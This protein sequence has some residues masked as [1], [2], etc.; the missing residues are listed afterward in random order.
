MTTPLELVRAAYDDYCA[1]RLDNVLSNF[2]DDIRWRSIGPV[3]AIPWAGD[4]CGRDAVRDW[5]GKL[6]SHL[7]IESY[8]VRRFIAQDEWVVALVDVV[9]RTHGSPTSVSF[10]KCDVL[11]VSGDKIVELTEYYDTAAVEKMLQPGRVAAAESG[12][13]ASALV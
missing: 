11:R 2:A 1:G 6:Q 8:T 12:P 5:F 13:V 7:A 4:C 10:D 9:V 3:R